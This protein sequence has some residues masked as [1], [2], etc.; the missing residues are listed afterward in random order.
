MPGSKVRK[1]CGCGNPTM[2]HGINDKGEVTYKSSCHQCRTE[3]RK[4]RKDQCEKCG[5]S[6][7]IAAL[8]VD[9][10][11]GD[12]SNNHK[13]NL[14]TLCTKCHIAKTIK[15]KDHLKRYE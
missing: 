6:K 5:I 15:N 9:H 2:Q 8:E 11:D 12:R 7:D 13:S 10:I 14:Q 1:V 4:H 3:A